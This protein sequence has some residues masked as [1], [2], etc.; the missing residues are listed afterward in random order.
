MLFTAIALAAAA[1]TTAG[2]HATLRP[3]SSAPLTLGG[4]GFQPREP[5][6]LTVFAVRTAT[7]RVV[8]DAH[9]RF[10]ARM[11]LSIGGCTLWTARAA[12]RSAGTLTYKAPAGRCAA[13]GTTA[14]GTGIAGEVRRGP[15]TPVCVAEQPCDAPAPNIG[16]TI[17]QAGA[18]VA[19]TTTG[20]DGGFAVSLTEGR[21]AV[22]VTG[23]AAP[24]TA[25]VAAGHVSRLDFSIDTGIR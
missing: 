24:Q 11:P 10:L 16:V 21:Y 23:R 9:G 3:V 25:E 1:A 5:V 12:G 14:V 22:A 4:T 13:A 19:R 2:T 17:S 15:I 6:R 18:V 8:A 20:A 7:L